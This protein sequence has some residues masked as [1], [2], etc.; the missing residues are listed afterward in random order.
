MFFG[1][2]DLRKWSALVL[3]FSNFVPCVTGLLTKS[4]EFLT[5]DFE[6]T[7]NVIKSAFSSGPAEYN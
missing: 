4:S 1:K 3:I 2:K 7:H 6:I 5:K